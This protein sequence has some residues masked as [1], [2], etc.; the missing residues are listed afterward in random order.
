MS[1]KQEVYL[2]VIYQRDKN[3]TDG[4]IKFLD[5]KTLILYLLKR[6]QKMI[7]KMNSE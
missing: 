1:K 7:I 4:E 6:N 3:E 2:I 5:T